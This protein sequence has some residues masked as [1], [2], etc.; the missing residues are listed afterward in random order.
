[1]LKNNIS[2]G[3]LAWNI[4]EG[5]ENFNEY[6]KSYND[7]VSRHIEDGDWEQLEKIKREDMLFKDA[8]FTYIMRRK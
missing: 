7:I 8:G 6:F 5:Y 2:G 4:A 3:I 1:L